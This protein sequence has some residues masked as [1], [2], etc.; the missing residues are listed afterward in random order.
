MN[1]TCIKKLEIKSGFQEDQ[2]AKVRN[3][4][5]DCIHS[6]P[7]LQA[8]ANQI[9]RL[10]L[11]AVEIVSN[12]CR[13]AYEGRIGEPIQIKAVL[14]SDEIN[15]YFQ[16]QSG[17]EFNPQEITKPPEPSPDGGM[18]LWIIQQSADNVCYYQNKKGINCV[19]LTIR[20]SQK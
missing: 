17:K 18:G 6:A 16:D 4:V 10:Q 12:I 7:I 15:L 11:A 9:A 14:S 20:Q 3:F 1:E 13:H 2:L 19:C 8:D 5:K